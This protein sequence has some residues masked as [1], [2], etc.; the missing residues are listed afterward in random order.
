MEKKDKQKKV[1]LYV[2]AIFGRFSLHSAV[3]SQE[4]R[5]ILKMQF[6]LQHTILYYNKAMLDYNVK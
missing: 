4:G 6:M 5:S 2:E 1:N 3:I